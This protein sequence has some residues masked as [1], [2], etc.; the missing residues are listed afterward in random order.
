MDQTTPARDGYMLGGNKYP[1]SIFKAPSRRR[2]F[3][4]TLWSGR[5]EPDEQAPRQSS[6]SLFKA[7]LQ[8]LR[9]E[10]STSMI[11]QRAVAPS[12]KRNM[13]GEDYRGSF[14]AHFD[15]PANDTLAAGIL[16]GPKRRPRASIFDFLSRVAPSESKSSPEKTK[17][18]TEKTAQP[19]TGIFGVPLR[20]SITY[21]NV[22]ISLVD[23]EGK[24]YIYGYVPIV[25]AKC[26]VYL[27]EKGTCDPKRI[28]I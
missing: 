18:K 24:S 7:P 19:E 13:F 3:A 9:Q 12:S 14:A 25:V 15:G 17:A 22:A 20:Q 11:F 21:A 16:P 27:K 5:Q 10:R 2:S 4:E 6:T 26:G 23:G 28:L 8:R 1:E